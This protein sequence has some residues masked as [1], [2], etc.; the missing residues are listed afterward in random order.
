[1]LI[2][3]RGNAG[4]AL[5]FLL[6]AGGAGALAVH[7][8]REAHAP[9]TSAKPRILILG[10][11]TVGLT[12]AR[13]LRRAMPPDA[14]MELIDPRPYMQYSA[15]LPEAGAGSI[16][17]RDVVAPLRK[18]LHGVSIVQ[19]RVTKIDHAKREVTITLD[20]GEVHVHRYDILVVALGAV[21][22]TMPI[23]GLAESAIGFKNVE[24]AIAMRNHVLNCLDIA[25]S[26]EDPEE[27]KRLLTFTFVGGGF[28]GIETIAELEDMARYA[29]EHRYPNLSP[30]ELKFIMVEGAPRILPELSETG[31]AYAQKELSARGIK[32]YLDTYL[33]SCI[34][35]HVV[36]SSGDEWDSDTIVW[37]AGIKANP[38]LKEASDLPLD[39]LG[40]VTVLPTLQVVNA[41]GEVVSD[42]WSAG[43]CAAVPD[44][45][46][47]G[48]FCPPNA[49]YAIREARRLAEN[50]VAELNGE[51]PQDFAHHNI[52][53]VASL[54]IKKGVA[55][56]AD[57][58]IKLRGPLA[59][60]V[61]R[62]YHVYAMPTGNR[63]ARVLMGWI[64][65]AI[66]GREIVSLGSIEDPRREFCNA[67]AIPPAGGAVKQTAESAAATAV[68]GE[69]RHGEGPIHKD[70]QA[71]PP[72]EE[73]QR[74]IAV[75]VTSAS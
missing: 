51:K 56:F 45:L 53:V 59:W 61:H 75:S 24:E 41:D 50:I 18:A 26:V 6:G 74:P 9:R 46:H 65:Q 40:R 60:M 72:Y 29:A 32:F 2:D 16:E 47:P 58:K 69:H 3:H 14:P 30:D 68:A 48:K 23:P 10:G 33:S 43:D 19:A 28:S 54:G 8:V 25:A 34:D 64:G 73:A 42:A 49:Q 71:A 37:T 11:G 57:A 7:A 4:K 15:F 35:G 44:V 27:R 31:S 70:D 36:V 21:S 17:A 63:K 1:M 55:E 66:L 12:V 5:A 13:E 67:C 38:L 62:A 22:R 52:G 20:D 39:K